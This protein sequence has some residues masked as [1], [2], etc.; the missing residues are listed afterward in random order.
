M[1]NPRRIYIRVRYRNR[2]S[3]LVILPVRLV[4]PR[5]GIVIIGSGTAAAV[6][7]SNPDTLRGDGTAVWLVGATGTLAI[8]DS[9][10]VYEPSL[11]VDEPVQSARLTFEVLAES[12]SQVPAVAP[13]SEPAWFLD[14]SSYTSDR[15]LKRVLTVDFDAAASVAMR[16]AA[17]DSIS[18][19]VIGGYHYVQGDQG[20]YYIGVPSA[21]T[22]QA[23]RAAIQVLRRQSQVV[24]ANMIARSKEQYLKQQ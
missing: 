9:T 3:N 22:P 23:L 21:T 17:I 16:Q 4:L 2:S 1:S 11:K 7:A 6:T 5:S 19:T 18:A 20:T 10:K 24:H 15:I 8:G 12:P 14:D 13:D